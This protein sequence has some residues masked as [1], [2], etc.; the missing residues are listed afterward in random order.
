MVPRTLSREP[1]TQVTETLHP[2]LFPVLAKSTD[3]RAGMT[4]GRMSAHSSPVAD[5]YSRAGGR[6]SRV[7]EDAS[8]LQTV[9][10][11]TRCQ[12]GGFQL[13]IERC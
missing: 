13:V 7:P 8:L 1:P 3:R 4:S 6:H 5:R 12:G 9:K 11:D 10:D 2:T